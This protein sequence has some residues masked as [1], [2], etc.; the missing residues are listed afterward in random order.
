MRFKVG[1]LVLNRLE[2][3]QGEEVDCEGIIVQH[4][5]TPSMDGPGTVDNVVL[6]ITLDRSWPT[7][8][9]KVVTHRGFKEFQ[10]ELKQ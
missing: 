9:N 3:E 8:T 7:Q 2:S 4:W 1:D 10:W 5:Q 6:Y